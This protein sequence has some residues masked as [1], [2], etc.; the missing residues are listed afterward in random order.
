MLITGSYATVEVMPCRTSSSNTNV[1]VGAP[2][3]VGLLETETMS[4][5]LGGQD[6]LLN[7]FSYE[8]D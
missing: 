4:Y 2:G 7:L 8:P 1:S 5:N 6:K 3:L